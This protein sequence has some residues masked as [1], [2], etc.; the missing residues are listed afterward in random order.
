M[1][2]SLPNYLPIAEG[3]RNRFTSF[4]RV[5]AQSERQRT[6]ARI[7][8]QIAKSISYYSAKSSILCTY[9]H[10]IMYNEFENKQN[11]PEAGK[12]SNENKNSDGIL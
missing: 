6:L 3:R 5:L 2:L 1:E 8:T 12:F 4:L 11:L 9:L 10:E 7:E